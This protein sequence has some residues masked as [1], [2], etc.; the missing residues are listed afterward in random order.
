MGSGAKQRAVRCGATDT[1][2]GISI[3]YLC[4]SAEEEFTAVSRCI[5]L[6]HVVE[7]R[8]IDLILLP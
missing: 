7:R 6:A 5:P 3:K 1:R 2:K 8:T 4:K